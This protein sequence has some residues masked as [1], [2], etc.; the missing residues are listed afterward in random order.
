MN[1]EIVRAAWVD[2]LWRR[3]GFDSPEEFKEPGTCFACGLD[4]GELSPKSIATAK[5]PH[6]LCAF[7]LRASKQLTGFSY[8]RWFLKRSVVE[9]IAARMINKVSKI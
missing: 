1:T 3:K 8:W 4:A 9:T 5:E 6:L 2:L 7:C